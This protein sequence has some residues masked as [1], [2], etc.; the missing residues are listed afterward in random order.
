[1]SRFPKAYEEGCILLS[2]LGFPLEIFGA[3]YITCLGQG[4]PSVRDHFRGVCDICGICD[5]ACGDCS[6]L[7]RHAAGLRLCHV[8]LFL[9]V[10]LLPSVLG[11]SIQFTH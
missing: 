1:M 10:P 3:R 4:R 2:Q 11:G 9:F 7:E 8:Y 6:I 5:V